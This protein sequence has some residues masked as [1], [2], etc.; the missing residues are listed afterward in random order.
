MSRVPPWLL[1]VL[2]RRPVA[3]RPAAVL[4]GR[5]RA[6]LPGRRDRGPL[7]RL[8]GRDAPRARHARAPRPGGAVRVGAW[9]ATARACCTRA[10]ATTARSS[11]S[12]GGKGTLFF[13]APE[14]EVHALAVGPDGRV[15]VGT[16]PDGKVYA[17]D[18][19]GQGRGLLRPHREVHLGA[20]LRSP[21]PPAG[22]H[23]GRRPRVPRGQERQ[24]RGPAAPARRR[25]SPP[26]P[27]TTA[28]NIFAGSSPAAIVYRIDTAG[29]VFVL[30]DSAFRE[31]K[32]LAVG[33]DGSLYAA[34][35]DGKEKGEQAPT[36]APQPVAG[37][38]AHG[39]GDGHRELQHRARRHRDPAVGAGR[40]A[41]GHRQRGRHGQGR[42]SCASRPRARWTRC[43]PRPTRRPMRCWRRRTTACCSPPATRARSTASRTTAPGRWWRPF[44]PS[45]SRR[46]SATPAR[47]RGAGHLEPRRACT[48]W[49]RRPGRPA[50]SCRRSR[51]PTPSPAGDASAG[52]ATVP[53]GNGVQVQTRSGNTGTPDTTWS[54]WSPGLR[55][56]RGRCRDERA[57]ALPPGEGRAGGRQGSDAGAASPSPPPTC[58]A[59]CGRRCSRS[60]CTRRARSSR[61]RCR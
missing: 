41:H 18:R 1:A 8:R 33:G 3:P 26:W 48:R 51:T 4:E 57:R 60:P 58:S 53:A 38:G 42:G 20:G 54:D 35:V 46:C 55:P 7:G 36:P 49:S 39:R 2:P 59:T 43:G 9:P 45:R 27:W 21:G 50:P 23:R 6:R 22:G 52:E 11:A 28:G 30:H 12:Q 37:G 31:V 15:Y 5:G 16:S 24:G 40:D 17:V 47:G 13:D 56:R 44:P 19:D 61:S 14:L 25:T 32:A 29:K 34:V 10:P